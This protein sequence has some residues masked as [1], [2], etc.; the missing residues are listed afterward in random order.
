MK[1]NIGVRRSAIKIMASLFALVGSFMYV[2]ILAV[3]NGTLGFLTA[4]AITILGAVGVAK[5]LGTF[6]SISYTLILVLI[7]VCGVLRGL[8]R[9]VEQYSNHYI[10][11]KL[12][13][14][15]RDKIFTK[16]R[17][18]CPAKLESKQKGSLISMITADIETLEVFYAHTMSPVCI[19]VLVSIF[20]VV[21]IGVVSS[22]YLALVA[23]FAYIFIGLILPII[24]NSLM[25]KDGVNHRK[26]FSDFNGFFMDT[27]KGSQEI[28][29][30]GKSDTKQKE[31]AEFSTELNKTT[32]SLS[33]K[34]ASTTGFGAISIVVLNIIMITVSIV[35]L[36]KGSINIGQMIVAIVALISSYG[37]MLAINALPNSLNQTF[38]S[39]DRL[40][41]LTEEKPAVI[42][43]NSGVCVTANSLA[44]EDLHF[45]YNQSSSVLNGINLSVKQGEIVGIQ[46]ASGCGKSTL[47]KLIMR[48][49]DYDK[50]SIKVGEKSIKDIDNN[51]L[52][53]NVTLV[54]QKTYLFN[55]TVKDNLIIANVTATDADIIEACKKASIHEFIMTLP[56][57]Y[58]TVIGGANGISVSS[59]EAQ[60]MGLARAFL[61][62]SKIILLDEPT[63]NVDSINE[64]IIL[65]SLVDN[66]HDRAVILVSHRPSTMKV[67]SKVYCFN[68]GR[69]EDSIG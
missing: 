33:K 38:A 6:A 45:G 13:A 28:L 61:S 42:E 5:L 20:V 27:I 55:E 4:M 8:L 43:N 60:R 31:V 19:A 37:A 7:G 66:A 62:T 57:G 26:T 3:F 21:F 69:L 65:Q 16:L 53:S 48:F 2:L 29:L 32:A 22:W 68:G 24:N 15:L 58:D 40:I 12:L 52:K 47:L 56:A 64:G 46:G 59:G 34:V 9:Y 25:S 23:L 54:S 44:I 50:G 1:H 51:S 36:A 14:I 10:A 39:G 18:L 63:S 17:V 41:D 35:L 49:W 67:A 11:F 30:F